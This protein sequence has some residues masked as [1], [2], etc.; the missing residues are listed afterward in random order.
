MT[1]QTTPITTTKAAPPVGPYPHARRVG[2]LLFLSG[3]GPRQPG[4][5]QIP[6][7][8]LD[9]QGAVVAYDVRAQT[10]AC[11]ANVKAVLEAAG[12]S[13]KDIVDLQVFLVDISKNFAAF[14]AVYAEYFDGATGP[15]RT[16]L[17]VTGL[18]TPIHVEIKAIA[19][20]G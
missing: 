2:S 12:L 18:P 8:T 14:N 5:T 1:Q 19:A 15:T 6:G 13:M 3:I 7:V 11:F 4:S 10:H 9:A 20:Y 16:T 17:G